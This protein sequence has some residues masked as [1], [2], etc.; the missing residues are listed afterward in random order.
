MFSIRSH[1][2][3]P[4]NA[5]TSNKVMYKCTDVEQKEFDD[6]R[7]AVTHNPL[8]ENPDFNKHFKYTFG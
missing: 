2:L 4:L 7:R 1:L 6:I 5:L 3:Y 8:L